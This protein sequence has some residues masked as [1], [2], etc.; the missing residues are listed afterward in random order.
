MPALDQIN[1]YAIANSSMKAQMNLCYTLAQNISIAQRINYGCPAVE[2]SL[3]TD[4]YN[5]AT[6][7]YFDL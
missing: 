5:G 6:G 3:M 4:V 7:E 2:Y 1:A